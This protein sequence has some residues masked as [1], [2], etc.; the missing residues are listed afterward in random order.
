MLKHVTK[1][2]LFL[3]IIFSETLYSQAPSQFTYQSVVRN[4]VG[5]LI[6]NQDV[7]FRFTISKGTELGM[8]VF[9]EEHTVITNRNGLA[10]MIIGRGSGNDDLSDIDWGADSYYLTVEV[11]PEGGFNYVGE[12]T[13]QL[14]SVPY[15]LYSNSS[16]D[17]LTITGKDYITYDEDNNQITINRVDLT[18]DVDGILPITS[19]GTGSATAP[20]V[21][22]ITAA[23][24][25]AART[26]LDVDIAGTDNSTDVSLDA[27]SQDYIVLDGQVLTINKVDASTDIIGLANVAISGDYSDLT[28]DD[29][30]IPHEKLTDNTISVA[31]TIV[32][33]GGAILANEI[34][35]EIASQVSADGI[36][37]DQ[38]E[39]GTI[40]AT[41]ITSLTTAGITATGNIDIGSYDFTAQTF[42]SDVA[43]GT[44]PFTVASTTA[45]TNLNADLLDGQQGSYYTDFGNLTVDD[46]EIPIT[47]LAS[48]AI[49]IAGTSVSL[50]G[51]ITADEIAS[52]VSADGISG[53][54]VEGGTIAATTI[55]SLT[56]AGITASNKQINN[57]PIVSGGSENLDG[58]SGRF[59]MQGNLTDNYT[60][61]TINNS[62]VNAN[63]VIVCTIASVNPDLKLIYSVVATSGSF[64]ITLFNDRRASNVSINFIVIN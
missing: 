7:S 34:A 6:A 57:T 14:L 16:G 37:G 46:D 10:T 19:G 1:I 24:A 18:D 22:V 62:F 42:T 36:S 33:L 27:T 20:M 61:A 49:T 52:Q 30:E 63:S 55:T 3:L 13:T 53:D 5:R 38:V 60:T 45:V 40:A 2:L 64:E 35:D 11:D 48:D 47:K 23:D 29:D 39:G 54:Q 59:I 51:S 4:E 12:D 25:A 15:A 26:V 17:K 58:T 8:I 41:T 9:E 50:G 32:S 44:A 56:T 43:T 21:G 31:G 28:V